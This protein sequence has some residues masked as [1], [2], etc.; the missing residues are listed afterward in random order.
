MCRRNS[1]RYLLVETVA[2]TDKTKQ[3]LPP[4]L[5]LAF[6]NELVTTPF[7]HV[8]SIDIDSVVP[9]FLL[10][11]RKAHILEK[12]VENGVCGYLGCIIIPAETI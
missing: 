6:G 12:G 5:H 3:H 7:S 4:E 10:E 9:L 1:D 2:T 11:L 8:N